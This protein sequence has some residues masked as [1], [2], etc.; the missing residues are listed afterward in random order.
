MADSPKTKKK[1]DRDEAKGS[2]P[3]GGR[4]ASFDKEESPKSKK[5]NTG[6]KTKW[7]LPSLPSL[8]SFLPESPKN[9]KPPASATEERHVFSLLH[10]SPKIRKSYSEDRN[11]LGGCESPNKKSESPKNKKHEEK[12]RFSLLDSPKTK[13]GSFDETKSKNSDSPKSGSPKSKKVSLDETKSKGSESPKSDRWRFNLLDSPKKAGAFEKDSERTKSLSSLSLSPRSKKSSTQ[14]G[15]YDQQGSPK[16]MRSQCSD[17]VKVTQLP[18]IIQADFLEED[19]PVVPGVTVRGAAIEKLLELSSECFDDDGAPIDETEYPRVLFL[20]HKWFISSED[21]ADS[22]VTLY[23]NADEAP[24]TIA[25]CSH[26]TEDKTCMRFKQRQKVCHAVGYWISK[27]PVHF[28]MDARLTASVNKLSEIMESE[29]NTDMREMIDISR[30]PNFDWMRNMSVRNPANRLA[31]KQSLVFNQLQPDELAEQLTF[32][33]YKA[34]RRITFSDFKNYAV[35]GS[36]KDNP[37]LA[38]SITVFNGLSQWVQC[39]VLSKTT[40][41]QRSEV[42]VKFIHVAKRL[43]ELQNYNTLMAVGGGLTHSALARLGKTNACLP[44]ESQKILADLAD[45]LSSSNNFSNYRKA[46]QICTGFRI[47]IL[48]VHLKDLI[49]LHTALPDKIGANL[50]N[51]RKMTQLSVTF[52]ELMQVQNSS[53]PIEVNMDMVSILRLSLDLHYTEDEIYELSLAREPRNSISSPSTPT[54]PVVFGDWV[55]GLIPPDS[56]TINKHVN[57]MVEAVFKIYDHDKDGYIS[58]P[59][60]E[61]IAGNFPFIDSFCVLDA[62]QDGMIS[63]AEMKTY[64]IRANCHA[65]RNSFKHAFHET[66]Y[67]KPTFCIHCTGLLWGIIKQGHKCKDCGINAHKHCKDLVVMEC[68]SRAHTDK[69]PTGAP[70]GAGNSNSLPSGQC[71]DLTLQHKRRMSQRQRRTRSNTGTQTDLAPPNSPATSAGSRTSCSSSRDDLGSEASDAA[72]FYEDPNSLYERLVKA[73]EDRDKLHSENALL[74]CKLDVQGETINTL[75]SHIGLIRQH[76]IT[77][78]LDQMDTLHIQ[79]DTEV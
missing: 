33:E 73:E 70:P 63:K 37:K 57:A 55:A 49:L 29:G 32:L 23:C 17:E 47:P 34:F 25:K 46:L 68:R 56:D 6:E 2:S 72:E 20:M 52:S 66:T 22:Y 54:K 43:R 75:K 3:R 11:Q 16:R 7:S 8:P 74:K 51:F 27:F 42:M 4:Q 26:Q 39:M 69:P 38:R 45:L 61:L 28:D 14:D 44:A 67:F 59:E 58:Q 18:P 13:K 9:Q 71:Q 21:L 1:S 15:R 64:F 62:D 5:S 77:F 24:C 40:P 30:V 65:L 79:R 10:G 48:G 31:Q 36:L 53:L 35:T 12:A 78:I 60:F 19:K 50:I 41:Q 76:T